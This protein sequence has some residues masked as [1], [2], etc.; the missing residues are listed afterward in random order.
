[1]SIWKKGCYNQEKKLKKTVYSKYKRWQ[2]AY[3]FVRET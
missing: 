2:N 1:M 3:V